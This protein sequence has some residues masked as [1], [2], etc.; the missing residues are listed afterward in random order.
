MSM[1]LT[2][3][4]YN[5]WMHSIS[6]RRK[7]PVDDCVVRVKELGWGIEVNQGL[8]EVMPPVPGCRFAN[9]HEVIRRRFDAIWVVACPQSIDARVAAHQARVD[10]VLQSVRA[11]LRPL[12]HNTVRLK[13][14]RADALELEDALSRRVPQVVEPPVSA[15]LTQAAP[16]PVDDFASILDG[17]FITTVPPAALVVKPHAAS[18]PSV[19]SDGIGNRNDDPLALTELDHKAVPREW[20]RGRAQVIPPIFGEAQVNNGSG[21][22]ASS[23]LRPESRAVP[24]PP[25]TKPVVAAPSPEPQEATAEVIEDAPEPKA[26]T[27]K[28]AEEETSMEEVV[29]AYIIPIPI[30][31]YKILDITVIKNTQGDLMC[32]VSSV[33]N[34]LEIDP[35]HQIEIIKERDEWMSRVCAVHVPGDRARK[36]FFIG[37]RDLRSWL[38]N[39]SRKKVGERARPGLI[40]LQETI[41]EVIREHFADTREKTSAAS[42]SSLEPLIAQMAQMTLAL[43]EANRLTALKLDTAETALVKLGGDIQ[44][45]TATVEE[46]STRIEAV[47]EKVLDIEHQIANP[48]DP[49]FM[50]ADVLVQQLNADQLQHI[51][52]RAGRVLR[53]CSTLVRQDTTLKYKAVNTHSLFNLVKLYDCGLSRHHAKQDNRYTFRKSAIPYLIEVLNWWASDEGGMCASTTSLDEAVM[54][55]SGTSSHALYGFNSD[56]FA[57]RAQVLHNMSRDAAQAHLQKVIASMP[58]G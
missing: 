9:T 25:P 38:N 54:G 45:T 23:F 12:L 58:Q 7:R 34:A 43:T 18:G 44:T 31:A 27:P 8:Y 26:P 56:D 4:E 33:C 50:W 10:E 32:A 20:P 15:A 11:D 52:R 6:L 55:L 30:D 2:Q 22:F 24:V 48:R 37:L 17:S 36:M 19:R 39:I 35:W 41:S 51:Y 28:P 46:Q 5:V 14:A 40:K 53:P 1:T 3:H 29:R 47:Q 13:M 42:T 16:E 21:D 49:E 57:K